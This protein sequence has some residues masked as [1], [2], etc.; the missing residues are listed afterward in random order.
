MAYFKKFIYL[1]KNKIGVYAYSKIKLK[2]PS[3]YEKNI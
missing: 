3:I 2:T 1:F